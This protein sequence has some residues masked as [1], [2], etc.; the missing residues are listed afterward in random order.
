MNSSEEQSN[1]LSEEKYEP[2]SPMENYQKNCSDLGRSPRDLWFVFIIKFF[3]SGAQSAFMLTL[4]I[5]IT[6]IKSLP[7]ITITLV[8]GLIGFFSVLFH[9]LFGSLPDSLG[10]RIPLVIGSFSLLLNTLVFSITTNNV[11]Q[12]FSVIIF[13]TFGGTLTHISLDLGLKHYTQL[14]YRSVAIAIFM[15]LNYMALIIGGVMI[16]ILLSSFEKSESSFRIIFLLC[17]LFFFIAMV[18]SLFLRIMDFSVYE[19][20]ELEQKQYKKGCWQHMRQVFILKKF[21]RLSVL[22]LIL[23]L[24]KVIFYQQTVMLP[25]YMDRDLD[26]DSH[27]GLMIILNQV[28]I[29]IALPIFTYLTYDK[30]LYDIFIYGGIIAVFSLV[31]FLFGPSYSA[32]ILYIVI[33]SLGESLY[34][35]KIL[36]YLLLISPKGKEGLFLALI[37]IPGSMNIA[38]SGVM[39]GVL[40]E[41]YCPEDGESD[42]WFMWTIVGLI[43]LCGI[44][45]LIIFR[46]WIEEPSFESQ[47]YVSCSKEFE[48]N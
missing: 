24:I 20:K 33:S 14:H 39:A 30:K 9:M 29:I 21:W 4:P 40:L 34:G 15:G 47:P 35:P 27:Y 25:L 42:C 38:F 19:N 36:E 5:Y 46:K 41:E 12:F 13:H 26:D 28:V 18:L 22:V 23:L 31:P 6:D 11:V 1:L 48:S 37:S 43:A 16:E 7:D 44:L 3:I 8:Y 10:I 32:V 2:L 45:V 17:T